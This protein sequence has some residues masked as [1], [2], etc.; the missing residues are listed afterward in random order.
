MSLT[1]II[2]F[3]PLIAATVILLGTRKNGNA[4][5]IVSVASVL[6]TLLCSIA[7][8]CGFGHD[9]ASFT[10]MKVGDLTLNIGVEVNKHYT[11]SMMFIVTF[12]G[13]LVHIFSLQY[14]KDDD[15]KARFFG[16]LSLFMFSMTGIVLADNL[17]MMFIF[18]EL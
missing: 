14:M 10:W 12:I 3:L 1:F 7:L 6:I 17:A 4:S 8:L 9:P 5:A 16:G 15:A 11:P 18:W 13:A 2:L